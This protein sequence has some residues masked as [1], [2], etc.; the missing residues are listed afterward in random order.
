MSEPTPTKADLRH[1]LRN[2]EQEKLALQ[3][4]LKRAADA[5]EGLSEA[6]CSS[7]AK[8]EAGQTVDRLRRASTL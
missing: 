3:G 8:H 6:D 7:D 4:L 2:K 5:L 1:A